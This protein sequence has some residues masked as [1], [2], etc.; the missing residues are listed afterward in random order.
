MQTKER[1]AWMERRATPTLQTLAAPTATATIYSCVSDP[2][3]SPNSYEHLAFQ[4]LVGFDGLI[5]WLAGRRR[6][7]HRCS[8]RLAL[9]EAESAQPSARN[10]LLNFEQ[11]SVMIFPF[12][13]AFVRRD[14]ARLASIRC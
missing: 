10:A 11:L 8:V 7:D 13:R 6:S 12:F 3:F 9:F 14:L 2:V 4:G 5:I 1:P